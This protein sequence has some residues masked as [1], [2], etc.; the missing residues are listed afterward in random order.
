MNVVGS[1][2]VDSAWRTV[3]KQRAPFLTFA[4]AIKSTTNTMSA[5]RYMYTTI[6][7]V[8]SRTAAE[9]LLQEIQ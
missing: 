1:V 4:K 2:N 9:L 6:H 3:L 8:R 5:G 7:V